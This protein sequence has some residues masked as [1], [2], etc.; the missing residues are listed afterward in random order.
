MNQYA[1]AGSFA[2]SYDQDGNLTGKTDGLHTWSYEYNDDNRLVRSTGPEGVQEYIYNGLG[3]LATV[4][5][6]GVEKH[7][8]VDPTG[9]GNVV[10]E[11]DEAGNL[12]SRYTH[13]L[14]LIAKDEHYYTFDGNG[15]TSEL[16]DMGSN[17]V[18]FYVYEPFGKTLHEVE[19]TDNAFRFVGQFGIMQMADDLLYMRNRFYTP[20]L[21]RFMAEDPIGLAGGDVNFNRYVLNSPIN[22]MDPE[23]MEAWTPIAISLAPGIAMLD[24]PFLPFADAAAGALIGAAILYDTWPVDDEFEDDVPPVPDDKCE[25]PDECDAIREAEEV[26]CFT[27]WA[28]WGYGDWRFQGCMSR[29]A[30]RWSMCKSNNG[31]MPPDAPEPWSDADVDGWQPPTP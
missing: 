19:T 17:I 9:F 29:A 18:N 28:V 31:T 25:P 4:I 8:L 24:S 13:G 3:Q 27:N 2:Y 12:V 21:G 1:Q 16:T 22:L 11:Y 15:N 7:Y 23:G 10:G 26:N 5:E 30:W 6:D 14:G 20:S